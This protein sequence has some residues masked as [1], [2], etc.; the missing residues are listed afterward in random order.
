MSTRRDVLLHL[1]L[2]AVSAAYAL[3]LMV[4]GS[5]EPLLYLLPALLIFVP[6]LLGRRPG[7]DAF[8]RIVDRARRAKRRVR[9]P[10]LQ[11]SPRSGTS[12]KARA[13]G[14]RLI[15]HSLAGRAP[16]AELN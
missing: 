11:T 10:L 16:P 7:E 4:A 2:A 8:T 1:A 5:P 13:T 6:L 9:L 3:A 15:A 14:G 12:A